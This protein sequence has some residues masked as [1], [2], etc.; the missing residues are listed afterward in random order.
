MIE[1]RDFL[2]K[3]AISGVALTS[4]NGL[5]SFTS[6]F[7]D[8]PNNSEGQGIIEKEKDTLSA[9][10]KFDFDERN[11]QLILQ[12]L[13]VTLKGKLRFLSDDTPWMVCCS[14]DGVAN[15]NTLVDPRGD[16]QGYW[17]LNT[18]GTQLELLF[19]HRTAQ[20][21]A[22]RF[23]FEGTIFFSED[24]F[25][26][27]TKPVVGER[28]LNLM[29]GFADSLLNDSLFSPKDD[30]LLQFTAANFRIQTVVKGEFS[31]RLSGRI[32]DAAETVFVFNME[33]GYFQKRYIP[34]YQ[35]IDR[36]RCPV[37]PTGWMSW[38]TYFDKASA[39]DNLAEARIGK[40]YLQPFGCEFWSIESWQ[41]NS[42]QL[43]V[44]DFYNMNLEVN[45]KQFPKGMKALAD[46]IRLLGFRPGL[47]MAPFGTGNELFY[48]EHHSW[49]LHDKNGKPISSWNGKYTLDPTVREAREH[50]REIHRIASREWG[51]E[52]FK[53]DGMSGQNSGYCAHLYERPEIRACFNDPSCLNPFELCVQAFREGM[54]EDRVFLACQGHTSGPEARY[55]EASRIGAD[56]VHPNQPVVWSGVVNQASCLVNQVFTHNIVMIADPDTLLVGDLPLEEA[57]TSATIVALPGQMTFFGD[58]L[59]GLEERKMKILQQTL[60]VAD[61]RPG[62]LYP[63]FGTMPVWNLRIQ[64]EFIGKYNVIAFFNWEDQRNFI[65]TTPEELGIENQDYTGFEFWEKQPFNYKSIE[66]Q[67]SLEVPPHAVRLV[68]IHPIKDV[69]QWI[70]SD[71][72]ITQN[73][74]EVS[75]MEWESK[76]MLLNGTVRLVGSF[77][78]S[79]YIKVP[80]RY[81]FGDITCKDAKCRVI[82]N[83]DVLS[84][85]FQGEES[86][87]TDFSIKFKQ[88][89]S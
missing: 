15:R 80:R 2:K 27:R 86:G 43:P 74:M 71:R 10:W 61:V 75:A 72:H 63:Y 77:P 5:T 22:G 84:I 32:E 60:P 56:I 40:K 30:L 59:A 23:S 45:E 79:M 25:P 38:N 3:V 24:A 51:Y 89:I 87:E 20:R 58:K 47:W 88:K 73:G 41:G 70:S 6:R 33:P 13:N 12:N 81:T 36:K 31:F 65:S 11:A 52:F 62:N 66:K 69:P 7:P 29:S 35:P 44:R 34:Y 55:A 37:V 78:L 19:Y 76:R 50:L 17:V 21:F 83:Q 68:A 85:T 54:G 67:F 53:I 57:R 1:R 64:H 4:A 46:E 18:V 8:T 48:K 42:D 16:V 82:Q 14:R 26:C 28:V 39:E 49:F 9:V